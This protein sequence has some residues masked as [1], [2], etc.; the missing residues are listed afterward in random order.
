MERTGSATNVLVPRSNGQD[1]P[2]TAGGQVKTPIHTPNAIEKQL[3][4]WPAFVRA[5]EESFDECAACN[6]GSYLE[7]YQVLGAL[8][9][10]SGASFRAAVIRCALGSFAGLSKLI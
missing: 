10:V 8:Q 2:E 6:A 1:T 7:D 5:V 3:D 4:N 9:L